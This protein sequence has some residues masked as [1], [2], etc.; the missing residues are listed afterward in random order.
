MP[1]PSTSVCLSVVLACSVLVCDSGFGQPLHTPGLGLSVADQ[2]QERARIHAMAQDANARAE[3]WR[4]RD[5]RSSRSRSRP[6]RP[7]WL[8]RLRGGNQ[9]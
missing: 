8:Q 3:A 2:V 4:N 6:S 9:R 7:S 5:S 1:K